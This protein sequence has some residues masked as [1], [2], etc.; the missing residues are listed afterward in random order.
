[1]KPKLNLQ[2][3]QQL[4]QVKNHRQNPI[5]MNHHCN[6]KWITNRQLPLL[7]LLNLNLQPQHL[8]NLNPIKKHLKIKSPKLIR[9]K[10]LTKKLPKNHPHHQLQKKS[11]KPSTSTKKPEKKPEKTSSSKKPEKKARKEAGKAHK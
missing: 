1:M 6:Q 2:I 8:P 5:S 4:N 7:K 11:E 9:R 10:N 3:I